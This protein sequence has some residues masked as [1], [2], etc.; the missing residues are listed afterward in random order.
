MLSLS[1]GFSFRLAGNRIN[2][3]SYV[4]LQ[5][6]DGQLITADGDNIILFVE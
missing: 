4:F 3:Q 1:L 5:D 2:G 6:D